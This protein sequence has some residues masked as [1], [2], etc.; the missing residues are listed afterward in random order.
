MDDDSTGPIYLDSNKREPSPDWYGC[1]CENVC[2]GHDDD[3]LND[4]DD[5]EQAKQLARFAHED[6]AA[7]SCR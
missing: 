3:Y 1:R 4:L 6:A 5:Y 7:D 2:R